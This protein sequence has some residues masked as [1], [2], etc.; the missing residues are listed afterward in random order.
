MRKCGSKRH[1]NLST[2]ASIGAV[3]G[4]RAF[5]LRALDVEV[6]I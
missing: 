6:D 2:L 3:A 5:A 1:N 4:Q